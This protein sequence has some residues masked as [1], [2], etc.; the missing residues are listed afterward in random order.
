[1]ERHLVESEDLEVVD[2]VADALE[3]RPDEGAEALHGLG[4]VPGPKLRK[5]FGRSRSRRRRGSPGG[6]NS[7]TAACAIA[8]HA[9]T[10]SSSRPGLTVH[11]PC[12]Q[13]AISR[14]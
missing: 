7:D 14:S 5:T 9:A 8:R 13:T 3:V 6:S 11:T 12:V 10:N 4:V 1:M 2:E